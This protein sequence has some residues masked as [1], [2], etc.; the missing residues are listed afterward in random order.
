LLIVLFG[1]LAHGEDFGVVGVSFF[2]FFCL[3][4][5]LV[6]GG[7]VGGGGPFLLL[8]LQE[9]SVLLVMV[10]VDGAPLL[11][12]F[13]A[14]AA[15]DDA[16]VGEDVFLDFVVD[17]LVAGAHGELDLVDVGGGALVGGR[18][19]HLDGLVGAALL[20]LLPRILHELLALHL[21][22][23]DIGDELLLVLGLTFLLEVVEEHPLEEG[24]AVVD[25]LAHLLQRV[26]LLR[27]PVEEL[28]LRLLLLLLLRVLGVGLHVDQLE[29][30]P[31]QVRLHLVVHLAVQ[32]QLRA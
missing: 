25:G 24:L 23:I 22:I 12:S 28:L 15:L 9:L 27:S 17:G 1:V 19:L 4:E 20:A 21:V 14:E 26:A 10:K 13:F 2:A 5:D 32:S 11:A 31:Q 8:A 30:V 7:A 3:F 18:L 6:E 29:Q 16:F